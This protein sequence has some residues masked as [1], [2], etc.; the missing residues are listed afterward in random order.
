MP[1]IAKRGKGQKR[2]AHYQPLAKQGQM[3]N[4]DFT[5]EYDF[6]LILKILPLQMTK[7]AYVFI[8]HFFQVEAS[9]INIKANHY[10]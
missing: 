2:H 5:P 6:D 4:N 8:S 1:Y 3:V 7:K 10:G 9:S